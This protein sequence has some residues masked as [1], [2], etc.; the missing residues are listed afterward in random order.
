MYCEIRNISKFAYKYWDIDRKGQKRGD[1][2]LVNHC[3]RVRTK[4]ERYCPQ[5]RTSI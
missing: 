4:L 2:Q 1:Y 3:R 5:I